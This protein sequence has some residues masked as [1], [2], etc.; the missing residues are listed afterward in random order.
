MMKSLS[1]T[2]FKLGCLWLLALSF[3]VLPSV[4]G[5]E[6]AQEAPD[7]EEGSCPD[8]LRFHDGE[9]FVACGGDGQDECPK[10]GDC[11]EAVSA[12]AEAAVGMDMTS[13]LA[14]Q[15]TVGS[16]N[17]TVSKG[18][19]KKAYKGSA[20][21]NTTMA[22]VALTRC[23]KCKDA[24]TTCEE[25]CQTQ[26]NNAGC[27]EVPLPPGQKEICAKLE[28]EKKEC[29]AK[30][31][32]CSA[33]C[34]QALI[35][36]LQAFQ[37]NLA[38]NYMSDCQGKENC[39]KKPELEDEPKCDPTEE[40]CPPTNLTEASRPSPSPGGSPHSDIGTPGLTGPNDNNG[41]DPNSGLTPETSF[42]TTDS[43]KSPTGPDN[44]VSYGGPIDPENP[45]PIP[46][47]TSDSDDSPNTADSSG[48]TRGSN[49]A[50]TMA[51]G[52]DGNF[53]LGDLGKANSKLALGDKKPSGDT[54]LE[55]TG[56]ISSKAKREVSGASSGKSSVG[57]GGAKSDPS[58]NTKMAM[59]GKD[60][61]GA[62]RAKE[63]IFAQMSRIITKVC[64]TQKRCYE[65]KSPI[66]DQ[67]L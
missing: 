2:F 34:N 61:L 20:L 14:V 58:G 60:T 28:A 47:T 52:R 42:A 33:S 26:S 24:M 5:D 37:N 32:E 65:N 22:S 54:G 23:R 3:S 41:S 51:S 45:S 8:D 55:A 43:A 15:Q 6:G 56:Y 49:F 29:R 50:S 19:V 39:E 35:S 12:A 44:R 31:T 62:G 46:A 17:E 63:S 11:S 7:C 13:Y 59:A 57:L 36:G 67:T 1:L 53:A 9:N 21:I 64:H 38:A 30:Q 66:K 4:A 18:N 25:T 27:S 10:L 40:V 16:V 48:D